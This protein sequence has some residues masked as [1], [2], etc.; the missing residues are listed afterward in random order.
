MREPNFWVFQITVS[1]L[2]CHPLRHWTMFST[3][4][5]ECPLRVFRKTSQTRRRK[6]KMVFLNKP[7]FTIALEPIPISK[8]NST[9]CFGLGSERGTVIFGDQFPFCD[10]SD[11][12]CYYSGAAKVPAE[13]R[14]PNFVLIRRKQR[15]SCCIIGLTRFFRLC[16]VKY[17]HVFNFIKE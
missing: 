2:V 10:G 4:Q 6:R 9:S 8:I 13:Q 16:S 7:Y 12:L 1:C 15:S 5:Q 17:V 3:R 14:N 11:G